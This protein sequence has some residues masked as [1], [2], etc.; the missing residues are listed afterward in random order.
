M[1]NVATK[2]FYHNNKLDPNLVS[3]ICVL[4]VEK[5]NKKCTFNYENNGKTVIN[6]A[7]SIV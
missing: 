5:F 7:F 3:V 1:L 6:K 2:R 4:M